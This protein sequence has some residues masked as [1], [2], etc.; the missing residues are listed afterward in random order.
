M[1]IYF[2]NISFCRHCDPVDQPNMGGPPPPLRPPAPDTHTPPP[3][4]RMWNT[5]GTQYPASSIQCYNS[6][7]SHARNLQYIVILA[8]IHTEQI[9]RTRFVSVDLM[10]LYSLITAIWHCILWAI[11]LSVENPTGLTSLLSIP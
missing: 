11:C 5:V 4:S 9:R 6:L 2:R 3:S 1:Y 7:C 10:L 8:K